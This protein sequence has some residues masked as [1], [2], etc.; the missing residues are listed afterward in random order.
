MFHINLI[1]INHWRLVNCVI[2]KAPKRTGKYLGFKVKSSKY[3]AICLQGKVCDFPNFMLWYVFILNVEGLLTVWSRRLVR[4]LGFQLLMQLMQLVF[5]EDW[6]MFVMVSGFNSSEV[7]FFVIFRYNR[8]KKTMIWLLCFL[9]LAEGSHRD[10][11]SLTIA[12]D[13]SVVVGASFFCVLFI[14]FILQAF[15]LWHVLW[16]LLISGT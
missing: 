9:M 5:H 2:E 10:L 11:P 15:S 7:I 14:I 4:E 16:S 1:Y 13:S 3:K 12:R 8:K 6:L